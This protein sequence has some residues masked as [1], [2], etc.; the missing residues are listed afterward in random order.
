MLLDAASAAHQIFI[1]FSPF[2]ISLVN[3]NGPAIWDQLIYRHKYK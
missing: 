1:S 3:F 2:F